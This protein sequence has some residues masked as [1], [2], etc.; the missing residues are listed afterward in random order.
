MPL[1]TRRALAAALM[2]ASGF[3]C[4]W[5]YLTLNQDRL[6]F[7]AR[8]RPPRDLPDGIIG[9]SHRIT[10]GVVRGYIYHAPGDT[11]RDL[12]FYLPGRGEDVLKT[13]QYARWL[14]AGMGFAT[15]DYRGLGHSDGRP[16]E[17]A[18]VADASQFLLHVRRVFPD[19]RVHVVGRSLGTGVAI[20]L[21]ELQEFESL[22]LITPYDSLLELVRKRFPLVPLRQLM[23]HH[24]DSISH[25]KKVVQS[26]KVLLAATDEVVP[27]AC[28]ERLMA[29]WPG[30]VALQTV[31]DTDHFTIIER[32]QTWLSLCEF[33][34]QHSQ[35]HLRAAAVQA[36][37]A[38]AEP[39]PP[40]QPAPR[41][42]PAAPPPPVDHDE[43][44]NPL[45]LA[46]NR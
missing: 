22:Q 14:P 29:A 10:G 32:E 27:H 42:A 30:P 9:Y 28:S 33:A 37:P 36:A 3:A 34:R 40:A 6:L 38:P 25:C 17:S 8:R 15:Y 18:A 19:T 45:P 24:F 39:A 31:P 26:T 2:T 1:T 35:A 21:A 13:L 5:T 43:L 23:R 44:G 20:Q 41:T 4:Y 7:D 46:A 12:L 11:V 16:S